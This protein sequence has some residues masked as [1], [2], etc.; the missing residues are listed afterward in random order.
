MVKQFTIG[1]SIGMAMIEPQ[2]FGTPRPGL[3]ERQR[4]ERGEAILQ[5]AFALIA[6]KGY[7]AMTMDELAER[8]GIS[9]PTLY[10]HF[11]SKQVI[12]VRAA[13]KL[14]G[15]AVQSIRAIDRSLSPIARLERV[16]RSMIT[17]CL[18]PECAAFLKAKPV[19]MAD[20]ESHPDFIQEFEH[21][22]TEIEGLFA[23]AQEAGQVKA[24]LPGRLL[25]QMLFTLM[26]GDK[27]DEMIAGGQ[28]SAA[29]IT[30]T[31]ITVFFDG[32]RSEAD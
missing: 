24:G 28:T 9:K 11:A 12:A 26:H 7:E 2:L 23:A 5:A 31:L 8:A 27:Y 15:Q 20:V 17:D 1:Y 6:E 3:R 29:E 16:A 13:V 25:A 32:I 18:A 19:M 22:R 10:H 14:V 21:L 30:E 4:Q